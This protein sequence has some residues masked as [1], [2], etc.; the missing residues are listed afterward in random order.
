MDLDRLTDRR[1]RLSPAKKAL[2]ERWK[3]SVPEV[4][5][6]AADRIPRRAD[7]GPAPL[8]FAQLRLWTLAE[9]VPSSPFYNLTAALRLEG[10]LDVTVLYRSFLELVRRHHILRTRFLTDE[11]GEPV[12][13]VL[14]RV[15][16]DLPLI[17]LGGLPPKERERQMRRLSSLEAKRPADL[18]SGRGLWSTLL[19]LA[20]GDHVILLRQH[21]IY[22]D[23]WSTGVLI[24]ELVT[25]Y[26]AFTAGE[27]S[28]LPPLPIQYADFAA[29]QRSW[30]TGERLDRQ[31]DYWV[32]QL[33]D[34]PHLLELPLDR[35]RPAVQSYRGRFLSLRLPGALADGLRTLCR[36]ES[37]TLFVGLLAGY[38][39]LLGRLARQRTVL[40]GYPIANRTRSELEGL[41]GIFA[42]TLVLRTDLDGNP[43]FRELVRRVHGASIGAHAHQ[44]LPFERLV[45]ELDLERDPSHT[46][47]FQVMLALQ[48]APEEELD[49]PGLS[50]RLVPAYSQT[51]K[52]DFWVSFSEDG[53]GLTGLVEANA[54]IFDRSTIERWMR[55]LRILL[56]EAS[57]APDRRLGDLPLME[58]AE[59]HQLLAEWND[60]E[61]RFPEAEPVHRRFAAQAERTPDRVAVVFEDRSVSYRALDRSAEA[62]ARRLRAAGVGPERTV[63]LCLERSVELVVAL[64]AVLKSGGTYLPLDPQY[65][66]H[67]LATMIADGEPVLIL[68]SRRLLATLPALTS[69]VLLVEEV[70]GAEPCFE[71]S[72]RSDHI[73]EGNLAY[74][75]FT[76]GSTGRPKGVM[77]PHRGLRNRLQ[78]MQAAYRLGAADVVLQKTPFSFD[79]SV[80]EFFW[81]LLCGATLVVARPQGH[82]DPLYMSRLARDRRVTTLHFVPSMMRPFL[83]EDAVTS[84]TALRRV[85]SSGE[86]LARE[87]EN[88]FHEVLD[89]ELW[90]LYGPT[91]ASIDVS[92]WRCENGSERTAVPIG[93]PISNLRLHVVDDG[94][95]QSPIS[96]PG[97]LWIAGVGLARGYIGRPGL[98]AER[99]VPDP[100]SEV[101]GRAYRTG[102]L[103]RVLPDGAIEFLGRLDHQVKVRGLRIELG[104]I[105]E[106]LREHPAVDEAVAVVRE[107]NGDRTLVA[108][109][110]ASAE[111]AGGL[112]TLVE[113]QVDHWKDVFDGAYRV[114]SASEPTRRNFAG[115][116]SSYTGEPIPEPEMESWLDS[117]VTRIL[118]LEPE[119]ILEIGCGTGLFLFELAQHCRSYW[120]TDVSRRGLEFIRSELDRERA[121]IPAEI[122]LIEQP[123]HDLEGLDLRSF[124]AVILNSV[125]Q[126][127][128]GEGYLRRVLDG[129]VERVADGGRIFL[130]D[131]RSLGLLDAFHASVEYHA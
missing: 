73:D 22:S 95:R 58:E 14:E 56:A 69:E 91:E 28:P 113:A 62:L 121:D 32:E 6:A 82:H 101:G 77:V 88:R 109:V 5:P 98:T 55:A 111:A 89:A 57:R 34:C 115:W 130:G 70:I 65:P 122:R 17:D 107:E 35:P 104:E 120:G 105:E 47:L 129:L 87:L 44:D 100:F 60:T 23:A 67:R 29:W 71:G 86:V 3:K 31:L 114:G 68:A 39:A 27:E 124:D 15:R 26:R 41:L 119:R 24:R 106:V 21:H 53:G 48:N 45:E 19:R 76:S 40:V 75:I 128:P 2:L 116:N 20:S 125:V 108:H 13:V 93:R 94:L 49:L 84:C 1:S 52:F 131:L 85:I 78:W 96:V 51:A 42:N 102:D 97:E 7:R 50:A 66:R 33:S 81:P 46:P 123:A 9:L 112:E 72:P 12:Q 25:L 54:D 61:T 37:A 74:V 30:L 10:E 8:S 118:E 59:Q 80:W 103:A 127:F 16:Q 117:T 92:A 43:S 64:L 18:S 126:Y 11:D 36:A 38:A 83:D 79:V 90:N 4:T 110:V 99:F 63:G